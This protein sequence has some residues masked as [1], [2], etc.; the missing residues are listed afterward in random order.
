MLQANGSFPVSLIFTTRAFLAGLFAISGV[1]KLSSLPRFNEIVR[2][3]EIIP[4]R[5]VKLSAFVIAT[6]EILV[7]A[8]LVVGFCVQLAATFASLLLILFAVAMGI[9]L[10]RGRN[11][12][13]CGCFGPLGTRIHWTLVLRSLLLVGIATVLLSR[14]P[15]VVVGEPLR[16]DMSTLCAIVALLLFAGGTLV[17]ELTSLE[18]TNSVRGPN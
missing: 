12:L 8:F 15:R 16:L 18:S 11:W 5:L 4:P 9:N 6:T 2:S 7:A 13:S 14:S 10:I 1:Q 3:Y 17:L